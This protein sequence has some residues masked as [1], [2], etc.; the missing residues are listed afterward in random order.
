MAGLANRRA[1]IGAGLALALS[2]PA[3]AQGK[4]NRRALVVYHSRTGHTRTVAEIIQRQTGADLVEIET[5]EPYP[6][7]YD[8]LVAQNQAEQQSGSLPPLRTRVENLADYD[9]VFIGSPLWN[10]RLTPPCAAFCRAMTWPG[11]SWRPS[12]PKSSAGLAA[13]MTTSARRPR[14]HKSPKAW[15][16]W[17]RR[18]PARRALSLTGS[19]TCNSHRRTK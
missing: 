19:K 3:L 4:G 10:V 11:R 16:F 8:A 1:V 7:D 9:V 15:P 14:R 6:D 5:V 2:G 18:R 12:P 17:A 13:R